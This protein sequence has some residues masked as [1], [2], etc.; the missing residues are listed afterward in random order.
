MHQAA[1]DQHAGAV[2]IAGMA[3]RD[4]TGAA[5]PE[6]P[7]DRPACLPAREHDEFAL[8]IGA[9][10]VVEER[11]LVLEHRSRGHNVGRGQG[12]QPRRPS[13]AVPLLE[14]AARLVRSRTIGTRSGRMQEPTGVSYLGRRERSPTKRLGLAGLERNLVEHTHIH[15]PSGRHYRVARMRGQSV[16]L[17]TR[18]VELPLNRVTRD[19]AAP[20]RAA[21]AKTIG[22]NLTSPRS[23]STRA[24]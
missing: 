8:V 15:R 19:E 22:G 5:Q 20:R 17:A 18:R 23:R 1:Q 4:A 9:L 3:D 14:P 6:E 24:P 13:R 10:D 16:G 11:R 21:L 2:E 7:R 12:L